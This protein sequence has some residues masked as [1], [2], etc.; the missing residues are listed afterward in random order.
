M[1]FIEPDQIRCTYLTFMQ[2]DGASALCIASAEGHTKVVDLLISRGA[3][4]DYQDKVREAVV[5][6]YR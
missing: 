6:S 4:V 5:N 3:T 2:D 1:S